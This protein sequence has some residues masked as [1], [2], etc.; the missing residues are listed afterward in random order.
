MGSQSVRSSLLLLCLAAVLACDGTLPSSPPLET[1]ADALPFST[2][3]YT[4]DDIAG[5]RLSAGPYALT[6]VAGLL[7]FGATDLSRGTELWKSDGTD[8]GT[9]MVKDIR[10]GPLGS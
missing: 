6:D 4:V 3:P 10:P 2:P 8:P 7:L 9:F 5:G 1:S